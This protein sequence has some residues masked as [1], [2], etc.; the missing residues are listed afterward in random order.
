M[1]NCTKYILAVCGVLLPTTFLLSIWWWLQH[2][3]SVFHT[4][5]SAH[6]SSVIEESAYTLSWTAVAVGI[7]LLAGVVFYGSIVTLALGFEVG[8]SIAKKVLLW[9][10][11]TSSNKH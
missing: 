7:L 2:A 9:E 10:S 6:S 1:L 11:S 3:D 8:Y 4:L 5:T